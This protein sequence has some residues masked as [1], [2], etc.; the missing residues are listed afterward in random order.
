MKTKIGF[1]PV[2]GKKLPGVTSVL[3]VALG[4]HP[5]LM[6][7]AVKEGAKKLLRVQALAKKEGR[8]ILQDEAVKIAQSARQDIL[9]A[10]QVKGT[11]VHE[12]VQH[13][14]EGKAVVMNQDYEKIFNQFVLWQ[15]GNPMKPVLQEQLVVDTE[16]GYA[17]RFDYYGWLNNELVLLDFKTSNHPR[18][19]YGLQLAAYR[20]CLENLGYP[21]QKMY[22]LYLKESSCELMEHHESFELFQKVK[23]IFDWRT[24]MMGDGIDWYSRT[25]TDIRKEALK[26]NVPTV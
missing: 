18:A 16:V 26:Q 20:H 6:D 25:R 4:L 21:V 5:A 2:G 12:A 13:Q 3:E 22:V 7:W 11:W 10:A 9:K 15:Q 24:T 1:Y 23:D 8:K 14:L 19:E 17:G